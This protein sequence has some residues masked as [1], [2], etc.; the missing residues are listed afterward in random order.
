MFSDLRFDGGVHF[1][2]N[3][4][5]NSDNGDSQRQHEPHY[6]GHDDVG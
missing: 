6:N 1:R 2:L 5:K 3:V 4:G